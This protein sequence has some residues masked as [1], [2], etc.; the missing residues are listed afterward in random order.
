MQESILI[1][2]HA[3]VGTDDG[4]RIGLFD[5]QR[6]LDGSA[7]RQAVPL[8]NCRLVETQFVKVDEALALARLFH[9]SAFA[10]ELFEGG[11]FHAA[12]GGEV[13]IDKLNRRLEPERVGMFVQLMKALIDLRHFSTV[14]APDGSGT[15]TVCS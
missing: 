1:F 15:F 8:V 4:G 11:L 5:D 9:T 2:G 14:I 7:N 10:V 3:L 13:V 6:S 12:Q